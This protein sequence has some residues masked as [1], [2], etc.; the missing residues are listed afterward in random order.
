MAPGIDFSLSDLLAVVHRYFC[1]EKSH[2]VLGFRSAPLKLPA[3]YRLFVRCHTRRSKSIAILL[4]LL[5]PLLFDTGL[6]GMGWGEYEIARMVDATCGVL[7][8]QGAF[9]KVISIRCPSPD[10][11]LGGANRVAIKLCNTEGSAL[12]RVFNE[13][14]VMKLSESKLPCDF[15]VP[16]IGPS[17]LEYGVSAERDEFILV[18]EQCLGGS[19]KVWRDRFDGAG[20]DEGGGSD[21]NCSVEVT[22]TPKALKLW[23]SL[24]YLEIFREVTRSVCELA[25][26]GI[27]HF[28][29][30]CDN[31]LLRDYLDSSSLL[32]AKNDCERAMKLEEIRRRLR[33]G[34]V[35][36]CDFGEACVVEGG[37]ASSGVSLTHARGT[38]CIQS[39]EVLLI[40]DRTVRTYLSEQIGNA[41]DHR[42]GKRGKMVPTWQDR[43]PRRT[44]SYHAR[45]YP[46]CLSDVWSLG[47]L[48]FELMTGDF[49]FD[50]PPCEG[51]WSRLFVMLVNEES[52]IFLEQKMDLLRRTTSSTHESTETSA[53]TVVER[54]LRSLLVRNPN[55]RPTARQ[56]LRLVNESIAVLSKT[57]PTAIRE[58]MNG[59]IEVK[60]RQGTA[61]F[62]PHKAH[63]PNKAVGVHQA[64][65]SCQP[66]IPAIVAR[67]PNECSLCCHALFVW[68]VLV[69]PDLP[70]L[71][72]SRYYDQRSV[73]TMERCPC[74]PPATAW[75]AK[76]VPLVLP[77]VWMDAAL[78]YEEAGSCQEV[79]VVEALGISHTVHIEWIADGQ[80]EPSRGKF[81][82]ILSVFSNGSRIKLPCGASDGT[83]LNLAPRLIDRIT[84][85]TASARREGGRV[86]MTSSL[87]RSSPTTSLSR[88]ADVAAAAN[89]AVSTLAVAVHIS[90]GS[91][92]ICEAILAM[93]ST[94][95]A[96][97]LA[98]PEDITGW[99]QWRA[100][101]QGSM[102]GLVG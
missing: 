89:D 48:L 92:N 32:C 59:G 56:A 73:G 52:D 93:R 81:I 66:L 30:K 23:R 10:I 62:E 36:I 58:Y 99:L 27:I 2:I 61:E 77:Y 39:P 49:L 16:V 5:C 25:D 33:T 63:K 40:S 13:V 84:K 26:R 28:D 12:Q 1:G 83:V 15:G 11:L 20:R 7:L 38:E 42:V 96:F 53:L 47:C 46:S 97:A 100:A 95:R 21:E 75:P 98:W 70:V 78:P 67:A 18:M 24:L 76:S 71:V 90:N 44:S 72:A 50:V 65:S 35:C 31:I 101:N 17:L 22:R 80:L 37:I 64:T 51:G 19:L 79:D 8:G 43:V 74:T 45:G 54:L 41:G 88:S 4:Q 85:W 55:N 3:I 14:V 57:M 86:L 68:P 9:G 29:L 91:R 60:Q 94:H 6:Y 82:A 102:R 34:L 69:H 87:F